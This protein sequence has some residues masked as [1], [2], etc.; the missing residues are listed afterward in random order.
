MGYR[1]NVGGPRRGGGQA[2]KAPIKQLYSHPK[3]TQARGGGTSPGGAQPLWQ[4]GGATPSPKAPLQPHTRPTKARGSDPPT[5]RTQAPPGHPRPPCVPTAPGGAPLPPRGCRAPWQGGLSTG[6][7]GGHRGGSAAPSPPAP[8]G[9]EMGAQG[10][11]QR[12]HQTSKGNRGKE[13]VSGGGGGVTWHQAGP[14][15]G[16]KG[17]A[18]PPRQ[19]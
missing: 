11:M 16:A 4:G 12:E 3:H 15:G 14:R 19:L 17:C 9:E 13:P 6:R 18:T 5:L 2:G 10:G 8:Q 7:R 1:A